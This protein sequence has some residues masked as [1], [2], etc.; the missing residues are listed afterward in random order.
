MDALSAIVLTALGATLGSFGNV[1]TTRLPRGVSL[2]GRSACDGCG[3]TLR[4]ADLVPVLSAVCG[5]ARA[6]CCGKRYAWAYTLWEALT[7]LLFLA[8][9]ATTP[10]FP[11]ALTLGMCFWLLIA[12]G[13]ID[14]R[15][16]LIPDVLSGALIACAGFLSVL[17]GEVPLLAVLVCLAVFGGQWVVSRGRWIGSGDVLLSVGIA[18][19]LRHPE[20]AVLMT[21]VA[22]ILGAGVASVLLLQKR[23]TMQNAIAFGP[24]LCIAAIIVSLLGRHILA[25]AL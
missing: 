1:L 23:T 6:R 10:A 16:Q 18:L 25:W 11:E 19:M 13:R 22:Y 4:A 24:F 5:G 9:W 2:G 17:Y 15:T 8:A 20:E 12:I 21:L 3:A 7:A 14:A